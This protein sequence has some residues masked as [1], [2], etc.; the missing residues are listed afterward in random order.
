MKLTV[1]QTSSLNKTFLDSQTEP[2]AL[3]E[4]SCL[5]GEEIAYQLVFRVEDYDDLKLVWKVNVESELAQYITVR[6]VG[7]V[8]SELPAYLQIPNGYDDDYLT[9]KP[10]LFPDPLYPLVNGTVE[11]I[12]NYFRSL[13]VSIR[14]PENAKA[15]TF[16]IAITLTEKE[17]GLVETATLNVEIIDAV[18]PKQELIVTQWFHSDCISSYYKIKPLSAKHWQWLDKF[19]AT[20]ADNGINMLLTPIFTPPLDTE[21]G[22]ERPTV[23]L[24]DIALENGKYTFG[25]AKLKR[26]IRMCKKHGI[27]YFEMAHLFTQWGAKFTPKI[28]VKENGVEVKKFGWHVAAESAE[29]VEFLQQFLPALTAFLKAEGVAE[30]TVFHISDEP[31]APDREQYRKVRNIV[32]PL[33]EGFRVL[34]AS[35]DY[36]LYQEGLVDTPAASITKIGPYLENKV[37]PLWAYYC[38]SQFSKVS[39][40]FM[41]M[42]SYRNRIIGLQLY[43]FNIEGFLQWGYNFY[44]SQLSR[45]V[46]NPFATT[47]AKNAFPS[48]DAFSVYPGE[49]EVIES[50][51]LKVFKDALQDMRALRLL[52]KYM[53]HDE[54]VAMIEEYTNCD[55]QFYNYPKGE[56]VMLGLREKINS[57]I[58]SYITK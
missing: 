10:G 4:I 49:N 6:E 11:L 56:A 1:F 33:I 5:K 40:R 39:N 38:C 36:P 18:L 42:P 24:V 16:P 43:T 12:P 22:R 15:G 25:F 9:L 20:A 41:A 32:K 51:R 54:I 29:Y 30:N 52:E 28:V 58:K 57:L 23:Q 50:L 27:K 17:S 45:S 53:T 21:V 13:W 37:S 34:D 3:K 55:L 35:S 47:D 26:W 14:V 44:Y 46:I 31:H 48:G 8:P 19:I 2:L 7:Q